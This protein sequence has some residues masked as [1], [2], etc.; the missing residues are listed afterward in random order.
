[1]EGSK[2][3]GTLLISDASNN[4]V[5]ALNGERLSDWFGSV[6]DS[7]DSDVNGPAAQTC[8]RL[9]GG[10]GLAGDGTAFATLPCQNCRR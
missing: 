9:P 8:L 10:L 3:D 1:M 2:G 7:S 6:S 5:R 4:L